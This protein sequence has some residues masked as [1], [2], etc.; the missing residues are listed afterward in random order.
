M[1][2]INAGV[3][4]KCNEKALKINKKDISTCECKC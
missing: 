1:Q 2:I 3:K 4:I